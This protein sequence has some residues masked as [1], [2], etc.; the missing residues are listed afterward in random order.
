MIYANDFDCIRPPILGGTL[1]KNG[2]RI[3]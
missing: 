2:T 1:R 3:W